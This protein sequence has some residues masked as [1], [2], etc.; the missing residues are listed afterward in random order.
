MSENESVVTKTPRLTELRAVPVI[1]IVTPIRSL[2]KYC[3]ALLIFDLQ[4]LSGKET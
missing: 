1:P 2:A 3:K 4:Q